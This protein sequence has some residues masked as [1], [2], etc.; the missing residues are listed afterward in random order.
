MS[1]PFFAFLV[2]YRRL[3][4][5]IA[6]V[7]VHG[8]AGASRAHAQQVGPTVPPRALGLPRSVFP[9]HAALQ[10]RPVRNALADSVSAIHTVAFAQLGRS[11]GYLQT[12][13]WQA[14]AE[15]RGENRLISFR[16]LASLFATPDQA[17]AALGDA[18]ASL[19][20]LGGP[21]TVPGVSASTFGVAERDGHRD[22]FV[23]VLQGQVEA[24]IRLRYGRSLST[25]SLRWSEWYLG[26]AVAAAVH[27]LSQASAQLPPPAAPAPAPS[28]RQPFVAPWGTGPVIKSPSLMVINA[29]STEHGADPGEYRPSVG[30]P[31]TP[32]VAPYAAVIPRGSLSRY[33][34][35]AVPQTGLAWYDT[36]TLYPDAS[37]ASWALDALAR[38]TGARGW[39]RAIPVQP[40][41]A[42]S[43]GQTWS[44]WRGHGEV[45][46]LIR[47]Q[48]V[49]IVLA[50]IG[51]DPAAAVTLAHTLLGGVPTWLH[52][53]GTRMVNLDGAPVHLADLNWYGAEQQDFVVGG[54]DYR[55]YQ[56][57]LTSIAQLGY[58]GIRLPFSNQLVEQNPIVT[59]HLGANPD[60]VGL[61]ALDIMDRIIGYAGALGLSVVLDNHRSE[62][63]WSSQENGLW[64]TPTYPD[65][66]FI[67][68]WA[69]MA[70]RYAVNNVVIGADLR[71]EP[72]GPATWGDGNA[73]TDWRL[74]AQRAG[75]AVLVA[76]PHLLIMVEGIQYY[77]GTAG[78]WW[79]GNLMG[80][81][82]APVS[83]TFADG[84]SARSQLV[85]SAHDYGPDNCQ[86]GC[87]WFN[88]T[89]TYASLAA[90]WDQYWGFI[91]ADPGKSYAA[92]VWVGEFGTCNY[93]VQCV[94]DTRP[95]S[96]GQWFS[97][98][99][100]YIASRNLSWAYWS[101]NGTQ[102]TA[103]D[104]VYGA[105]DWYGFFSRDWTAPVAWLNSELAGIEHDSSSQSG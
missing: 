72:H 19:W 105:L 82:N 25:R 65:D 91:S 48:N 6:L 55:P 103:G 34:R 46:L 7:L 44:G 9:A 40:D 84:T 53:D 20:E 16:Y 14:A 38:A 13:A 79:G 18:R 45:V 26:R 37:T 61:R 17:R 87:P 5:L 74:A 24:E 39:F 41:P 10:S 93:N 86:T 50:M 11:N 90:L 63:G 21:T 2:R 100:Q 1:T 56:N 60:L 31:L 97:S 99:V 94:T 64:Y 27:I 70:A 68:D 95:G 29:L 69:T 4:G 36:A 81:A 67:R 78:Y 28:G 30:P 22:I 49:L 101:A 77:G 42:S 83:L 33:A 57:I 12:T 43:A 8:L 23:L 96:Q 73:S 35:T 66:A 54:L 47:D 102:S 62:A 88:A 52:A 80:V 76:D 71:N 15:Y 58:T 85:Y 98:L 104:R 3:P 75:D 51:S 59:A 92:P 32:R 89:T